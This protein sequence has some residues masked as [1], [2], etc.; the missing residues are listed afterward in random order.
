MTTDTGIKIFQYI[1][2]HKQVTALEI[3]E[4][5]TI[6]RQAIFK[7]LSKL[8]KEGK[9]K[10]IGTPPKV[11]YFIYDEKEAPRFDLADSGT[12]KTIEEF[13]LNI[14]PQ[15]Q[16]QEGFIG[17]VN[18]CQKRD[19]P[20]EKTAKVYTEILKKY[21]I[22]KKE[23]LVDGMFKMKKT[24]DTVFVNEV[25]YLD[26]YSVE[27]FGKTKLGQLLLYAKQ[28]QDRKLIRELVDK[29]RKNIEDLIT[30]HKVD[31]VTFIP[32]TVKREIQIMRELEK[33]LHLNIP[34]FKLVKIQ[35]EIIVPQKTLNKL[36]DR[37][38][39]ARRTII[40][41]ES[42]KYNTILIIDDALSSGATINETAKKI[43]EA[44]LAQNIIGLAITGSY[45]GFEVIS[46]V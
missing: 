31:A 44:N 45:S 26:F 3:F 29:I 4:Y 34:A 22:Y 36:E 19:L 12:Q 17:F 11:F 2:E 35:T 43:K 9:I 15:G 6:S 16:K 13:F 10:K 46:E 38:E 24:F 21:E 23:G 37:I 18:W 41:G 39:N 28:S 1:K 27:I 25:F 33:N 30:S 20:I 40:L 8:Q 32:P 14:T 5:L 42:R 7:Q